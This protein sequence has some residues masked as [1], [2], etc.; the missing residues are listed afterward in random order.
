M[1]KVK[2]FS[3][4]GYLNDT[5]GLSVD[6]RIQSIKLAEK[7]FTAKYKPVLVGDWRIDVN[8]DNKLVHSFVIAEKFQQIELNLEQGNKTVTHEGNKTVTHGKLA[9]LVINQLYPDGQQPTDNNRPA[10]FLYRDKAGR[11]HGWHGRGR[12]PRWYEDYRAS[13]GNIDDIRLNFDN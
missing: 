13:G 10:K 1:A 6:M 4:K 2:T 7:R 3:L 5:L 12:R 9:Q 11:V 8:L